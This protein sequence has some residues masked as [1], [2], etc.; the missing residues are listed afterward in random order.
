MIGLL[1]NK[2]V[3]FSARVGYHQGVSGFQGELL[4]TAGVSNK[5][6]FQTWHNAL[7]Q[8]LRSDWKSRYAN[9]LWLYA[10]LALASVCDM[11]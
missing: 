6:E 5:V 3:Y 11:S 4:L 8:A 2:F 1:V 9:G 10:D 7:R